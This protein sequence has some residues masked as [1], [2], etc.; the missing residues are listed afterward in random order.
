MSKLAIKG[1]TPDFAPQDLGNSNPALCWP[2]YTEEDEKKYG[3]LAIKV[4]VIK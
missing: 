2:V 4:E 3:V 1:G